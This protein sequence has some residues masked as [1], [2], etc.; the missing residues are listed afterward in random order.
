[1]FRLPSMGST[2]K[3]VAPHVQGAVQNSVSAAKKRVKVSGR[4][5]RIKVKKPEIPLPKPALMEIT[6]EYPQIRLPKITIQSVTLPKVSLPQIHL[7][8]IRLQ[9]AVI[10]L[11]LS[12]LSISA[13]LFPL[14]SAQLFAML[15]QGE[16]PVPTPTPLVYNSY[17]Q[18]ES[19]PLY[20]ISEFRLVVPKINLESS[21]VDNVDPNLEDEYKDKLQFG[22]AH[23]KGSYLPPE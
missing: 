1:F 20:P 7:S 19:H 13:L 21:I 10:C 3:M 18:Q 14:V 8:K 2:V 9:V 16:K 23:A 12:F 6:I 22:V 15:P 17:Y 5:R 11:V 4:V